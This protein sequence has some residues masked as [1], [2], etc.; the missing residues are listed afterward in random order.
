[1][2]RGGVDETKTLRDERRSSIGSFELIRKLCPKERLDDREYQETKP[3][4]GSTL[5]TENP[6][7]MGIV[8]NWK[9]AFPL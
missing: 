2:G 4:E 8:K 5:E 3:P 9:D 6:G 7:P 1:L